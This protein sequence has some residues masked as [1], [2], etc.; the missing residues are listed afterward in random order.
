MTARTLLVLSAAVAIC[1]LVS[2]WLVRRQMAGTQFIHE[3]GAILRV[4]GRDVT[5]EDWP[6]LERC[7]ERFSG[8]PNDPAILAE[9]E[10]AGFEARYRGRS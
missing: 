4:E 9:L 10:Q 8:N 5:D 6:L 3:S 7:M 2:F 1:F